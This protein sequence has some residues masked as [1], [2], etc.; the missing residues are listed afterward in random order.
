MSVCNY[1]DFRVISEVICLFQFIR[2]N[3]RD[4]PIKEQYSLN[5]RLFIAA[6]HLEVRRVGLITYTLSKEI[7]IVK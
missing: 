6:A 7:L 3:A 2:E 1:V 5:A 4:V